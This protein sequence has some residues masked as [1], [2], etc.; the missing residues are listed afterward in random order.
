M[1]IW[2]T[3]VIVAAVLAGIIIFL[4]WRNNQRMEQ[5]LDRFRS[6]FIS[7]TDSKFK[8]SSL[9]A[10]EKISDQL[11]KLSETRLDGKTEEHIKELENKKGLI[12]STLAQIKDEMAKVEELMRSLEDDRKEKFGKLSQGLQDQ[13]TQ[14][15][16][17][18]DLTNSLNQVMTDSRVRGQWGQRIAEDILELVG[19][20][21]SIDYVQQKQLSGSASIPDFTFNLP[22][23]KIVNMD[24][25]F[26]LINFIHYIEA[27]DDGA[28]EQYIKE[29]VKDA[30]KSIK[31]VTTRDYINLEQ[32]TLDFVIVFIPHEQ[33]YAFLM[34]ND[35]QFIDDALKMKVVVCS[36]WTLYAILSIIK[37]S[38]EDFKMTQSANEIL[39]LMN[40]FNKQWDLYVKGQE[41]LGSRI[42]AVQT[43][44]A[45]MITTRK[46]MLERQLNKIEELAN[47]K[48][49]TDIETTEENVKE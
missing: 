45:K 8:A 40:A 1:N 16:K 44:Y 48:G 22:G 31:S 5:M 37:K 18:T 7:E 27:D 6:D 36:P 26:P 25:K 4:Q 10:L 15:Q 29:Y 11:V 2:I 35:R 12:D 34:E 13:I 19:M 17:L 28:R 42:E 46:N 14:T 23:G 47:R 20:V 39:S 33:G 49:L 43:E 24:A 3:G 9:D 21:E 30:R 41:T 38:V 32:G